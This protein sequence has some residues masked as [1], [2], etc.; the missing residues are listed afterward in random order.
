MDA[1]RSLHVP[2][3]LFKFM[4]RLFV[5]HCNSYTNKNPCWQIG[6]NFDSVLAFACNQDAFD[7]GLRAG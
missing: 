5:L 6:G 1:F 3:H 4:Y 7:R 2:R